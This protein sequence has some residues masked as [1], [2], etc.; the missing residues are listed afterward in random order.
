MPSRLGPASHSRR[1]KFLLIHLGGWRRSQAVRRCRE[2]PRWLLAFAW[3]WHIEPGRAKTARSVRSPKRHQWHPGSL[4]RL[5]LCLG[6][7][8]D[9]NRGSL[10]ITVRVL[11][12]TD[13]MFLFA[14]MVNSPH[15]GKMPFRD[16]LVLRITDG[17]FLEPSVIRNGT[18]DA[19]SVNSKRKAFL[20]S[21]G[22]A[23]HA[24]QVRPSGYGLHRLG[25]CDL[26]GAFGRAV[27]GESVGA[28]MRAMCRARR[29]RQARIYLRRLL[30]QDARADEMA[31]AVLLR[32]MRAARE[33]RGEAVGAAAILWQLRTTVPRPRRCALLFTSLQAGRL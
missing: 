33:A 2:T 32:P 12:P 8:F 15:W 5:P 1:I 6:R 31:R 10:P 14:E 3:T 21:E 28:C 13:T 23:L 18:G 4:P 19:C 29:Q 16:K 9:A 27:Y 17:S 30:S 24:M 7:A 25:P 22:R 20:F 26:D 11:T